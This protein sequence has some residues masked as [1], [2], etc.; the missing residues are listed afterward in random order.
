[1]PRLGRGPV[2]VPYVVAVL[3]LL[4]SGS[5]R[6]YLRDASSRV[7][8]PVEPDPAQDGVD[9]KVRTYVA[10]DRRKLPIRSISAS[11]AARYADPRGGVPVT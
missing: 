5:I 2:A 7:G 10:R 1:M 9:A 3:M 8:G 6:A 4:F 11:S